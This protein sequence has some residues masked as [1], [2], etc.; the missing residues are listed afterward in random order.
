MLVGGDDLRARQALQR[1]ADA[2]AIPGSVYEACA[3]YCARN[4]VSW[5]QKPRATTTGSRNRCGRAGGRPDIQQLGKIVDDLAVVGHRLARA[6][7]A[8]QEQ[9]V[10]EAR[11]DGQ[12]DAV[13]VLH[14]L[15]ELPTRP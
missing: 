1:A 7:A 10:P 4:G 5:W 11:I 8:L 2:D 6:H 14:C 9:P 15:S 13:P 3:L 12:I